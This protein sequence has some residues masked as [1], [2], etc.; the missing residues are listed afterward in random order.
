[1]RRDWPAI[2][3]GQAVWTG[4]S[5]CVEEPATG[6][7]LATVAS[8]TQEDVA[9]A[10]AAAHRAFQEDWRWRTARERGG[11]LQAAAQLMRIHRD[12]LG[13]LETLETGKPLDQAVGFDMVAAADAFALYGGLAESLAGQA[14]PQG[15][16]LSYTIMEPYGVV[17]VILPFNWPPIHLAVKIAPALA[18][19]NT[20]VV[21]PAEQAPLT[22]LRVAEM[23]NEIFPAGVINVV[24]GDGSVAGRVLVADERVRK[25][26]FTGSTATGRVVLRSAAENLTPATL[27]LGGKNPLIVFDDAD[28]ALATEGAV[29]GMFFNQGEACT[30]A[31]RIFVHEPVMHEFLARFSV[32]VGRLKVGDG[33]DRDTDLGPMVTRAQQQ[34]VLDYVRVG[35]AEGARILVQGEVPDDPRLRGGFFVAP[36]V[37]VDVKPQMR[38]AREEIFGPVV[39][40]MPFTDEDEAIALANGSEYGLVAAVYT[41]DMV[42]AQRIAR[43][44]DS[45][46]VFVNNYNRGFLG[47]PFGG[48]GSSGYG[49]EQAVT[50]INEFAQPKTVRVPS[51]IGTVPVWNAARRV[52]EPERMAEEEK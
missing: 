43:K 9:H 51:G 19:G 31:S 24:P 7:M 16:I 22:V 41:R 23:L 11:L 27:E 28:I 44:F 39:V 34:R 15:P 26:T 47:T 2:I 36:T 8:C 30:A 13:R 29:E 52:C 1:M 18:A 3:D 17:G 50:T 45:G 12:E 5:F 21:K 37:L 4:A 20:V 48:V 42:R 14:I 49:R 35:L 25:L 46:V 33:L 10:I 40:V 32:A 6:E 38:V